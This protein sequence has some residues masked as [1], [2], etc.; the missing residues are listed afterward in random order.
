MNYEEGSEYS[1]P[2]GDNHSEIYLQ[3]VPGASLPPGRRDLIV[4]SVYEYGSRAGFWR[5]M[6]LFADRNIPITVFGAAL[7]LERNPVAAKAIAEAGYDI[8]CHGW[9]WVD[10]HQMPEAEERRQMHLAVETLQKLTGDRPLGWYCRYAPSVNTRRLVV[11]EGGFLYDSDAY[12]DDLPYWV[13]VSG[14]PHLV[15]P[16]TLDNN[17]MKFCVSPGF[18]SGD[19]LLGSGSL[20]LLFDSKSTHKLTDLLP[21]LLSGCSDGVTRWTAEG[22]LD[23]R[24]RLALAAAAG[25]VAR[26]EFTFSVGLAVT[27]IAQLAGC[28]EQ[29]GVSAALGR[30]GCQ[31]AFSARWQRVVSIPVQCDDV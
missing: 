5:L 21:C 27:R 7:A 2:D 4:E 14:K 15:I 8:C 29:F 13:E 3:E 11:E 24:Q 30:A 25:E 6:R 17:D 12:N 20:R 31:I 10:F 23:G 18:N 22:T 9:R 26:N 1:I 19:D 28:R 16:Y